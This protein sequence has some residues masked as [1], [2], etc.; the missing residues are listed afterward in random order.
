MGED[1][2]TRGMTRRVTRLVNK[3][4]E[5]ILENAWLFNRWGMVWIEL[6]DCREQ[7]MAMA[8][9]EMGQ[10]LGEGGSV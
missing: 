4:K 8:R 10:N 6:K 7:T 3:S 5:T 1:R 2:P 9:R